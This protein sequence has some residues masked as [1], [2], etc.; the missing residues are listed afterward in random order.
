MSPELGKENPELFRARLIESLKNETAAGGL[1]W[2]AMT[3][4]GTTASARVTFDHATWVSESRMSTGEIKLGTGQMP[5][6]TR[7]QVIFEDTNFRGER[8]Y[9]YRFMHEIVHLMH[10]KLLGVLAYEGVGRDQDSIDLYNTILGA[11]KGG[12]GFSSLGSLDF[13]RSSGPA[14]Q[15][16]ED[17][18]ELMNMFAIDP[19]YLK[20]Y[21]GFLTDPRHISFREQNNLL[22]LD[23]D[24]TEH[25]F[26]TVKTSFEYFLDDSNE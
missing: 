8:E 18:V 23:S 17:H 15:T 2:D 13:Y 14:E 19:S 16:T 7:R 21:L 3:R 9:V 12:V 1:V 26:E 22:T 24:T 25:V 11:R 6:T 20:R 10:P 4:R 5:D